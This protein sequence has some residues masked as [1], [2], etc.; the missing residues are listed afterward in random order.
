MRIGSNL[1]GLDL[2]ARNS[3]NRAFGM[4]DRSSLRLSTMKRINRAADDPAGMIAAESL[5]S[6]I[7]ATEA[8]QS[9]VSRATGML[10]IADSAMQQVS[11][12]LNKVRGNVVDSASAGL[13]DSELKAKQMEV[14]AAL[15]A[16][17]RIGATTSFGGR[18]LFNTPGGTEL[19]FALSTDVSEQSTLTLP[20]LSASALGG[21]AGWLNDLATGGSAS[22]VGGNAEKAAAI[23]DE[24]QSQVLMAR[25]EAGAFEKYKVESARQTL[26][27]QQISAW[28]SYSRIVDT[29]VA[30]ESSRLVQSRILIQ[31]S[32]SSLLLAGQSRAMIGNLLGQA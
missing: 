23:L 27:Q 22:L 1:S 13:S 10:S 5:R 31:S 17:N 11:G 7:S 32:I 2:T 24:A 20:Q 28:D 26:D 21:D 30:E 12:L 29:D 3:L 8:A 4:F 6:E 25:A 16:I 18:K 9:N 14:D 15:Q 19:S